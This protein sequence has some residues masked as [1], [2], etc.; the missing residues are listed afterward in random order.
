MNKVRYQVKRLSAF[1]LIEVLIAIL[2]I[3]IAIVALFKSNIVSL[4]SVKKAGDLSYGVLAA[5]YLLRETIKDNFPDTTIDKGVFKDGPYKGL[6][7]EKRVEEFNLPM[8]EDMR[9]IVV[10]VYWDKKNYY[11]ISTVVSRYR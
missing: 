9:K 4:G 2:I 3:S 11:E 5:D 10:R 6:R 1:T 7:W 8:L